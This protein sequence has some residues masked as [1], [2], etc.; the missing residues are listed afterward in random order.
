MLHRRMFGFVLCLAVASQLSAGVTARAED[1][2]RLWLRYDPLPGRALHAYRPRVTSV[3]VPGG[4]A[5]LSAIR[6]ELVDGSSGLLGRPVP[7]ASVVDRDGAVVVG[8]P[9]SS[10]MIAGLGWGRQLADLGP[11]GFRL[12]SVKVGPY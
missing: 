12:R 2:Y 5:T 8:T 10:P 1:G 7:T 6:T 3:V 4:S 11:E 9:T